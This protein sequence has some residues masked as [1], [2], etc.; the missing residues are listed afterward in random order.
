VRYYSVEA[1]Q[2][3]L[4]SLKGLLEHLSLPYFED[5]AGLDKNLGIIYKKLNFNHLRLMKNLVPGAPSKNGYFFYIKP[6]IYQNSEKDLQIKGLGFGTPCHGSWLEILSLEV[7]TTDTSNQ[8]HSFSL[9][10]EFLIDHQN[11]IKEIHFQKTLYSSPKENISILISLQ[12][13]G[14]CNLFQTSYYSQVNILNPE[15]SEYNES[16]PILYLILS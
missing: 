4:T 5:E 13:D 7:A 16:I 12:T 9:N 8:T 1:I 14:S 11:T 3:S 2:R 10:N 6:N 15:N